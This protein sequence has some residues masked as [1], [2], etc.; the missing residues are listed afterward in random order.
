MSGAGSVTR[1]FLI[2]FAEGLSNEESLESEF[3]DAF[4][5]E[6]PCSFSSALA[7]R[8]ENVPMNRYINVLPYDHNLVDVHNG[9]RKDQCDYINASWIT[10]TSEDVASWRYICTQGP[11]PHTSATFWNMVLSHAPLA[12][13]MLTN[14]VENR[15]QK[16]HQYFP[17][18]VGEEIVTDTTEGDKRLRVTC[19]SAEQLVPGLVQRRLKVEDTTQGGRCV[20]VVHF[21]YTEWPDHGAPDTTQVLRLLIH[22]MRKLEESWAAENLTDASCEGSAAQ[23]G[24]MRPPVVVHCSAGIGRTGVF[25]ACDVLIRRVDAFLQRSLQRIETPHASW[26]GEFGSKFLNLTSLIKFL[27]TQRC[28]MVQTKEQYIFCFRLIKE[29]LQ[30]RVDMEEN[31]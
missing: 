3:D 13:A 25:C 9:T 4:V 19:E 22:R 26:V 5:W 7:Q 28:G 29:E 2:Q 20:S 1:H 24:K 11:M 18:R 30:L 12:I 14:F 10:N 31:A 16:C 6:S 8:P 23:V 21:H 15:V 27:R 17:L